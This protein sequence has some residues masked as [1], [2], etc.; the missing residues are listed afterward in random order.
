VLIVSGVVAAV[1]QSFEARRHQ[2]IAEQ[3]FDQVRK[4]AN[5]LIFDYHDEISKLE[6]TTKLR[7]KLVVD[8]VNYLNAV[9]QE[10]GDDAEL[11]KE[12]AIAYRKIGDVQG[13]P[14]TANLGKLNEALI[15]YQKSGDLLE[16]VVTLAPADTALKNELLKSY[17][18]L[19]QAVSRS[20]DKPAASRII[21]KAIALGEQIPAAEKSF[22]QTLFMLQMRATLGDVGENTPK[23]L[24]V[25]QLAL[26]DAKALYP[27]HE[28]DAA[29]LRLLMKLNQRTGS[30]LLWFG[31]NKG[32]G[33]TAHDYYL[34]ALEHHRQALEYIKVFVSLN[35]HE[36]TNRQRMFVG[37]GNVAEA[38]IK[39]GDYDEALK[40]VEIA[41]DMNRA[42]RKTD[43]NDREPLL[44]EVALIKNKQEILAAQ[45]KPDEALKEID[46]GLDLAEQYY[47]LEPSNIEAVW[48]ICRHSAKAIKLLR[49]LRKEKEIDKYQQIFLKFEK[50][51]KDKS[52]KNWDSIS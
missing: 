5:S 29:L 35:P 11:L 2:Q 14:Y 38:L 10:A 47:R 28:D 18:A 20:G 17:D 40:N 46:R 1:W 51:H 37:Y 9:S 26:T 31:E 15:S 50:I 27:S 30:A 48:W 45:G 34:Q 43:P 42:S 6:G 44:E 36:R 39:V 3:R 13:K 41:F 52:G 8:A 49:A 21:E 4:I 33:E 16:K 12:T 23:K 7:E 25:Y 19:A 32:N 22:E 24:E